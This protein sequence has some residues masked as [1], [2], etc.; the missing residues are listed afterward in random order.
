MQDFQDSGYRIRE[1]WNFTDQ[2]SNFAIFLLLIKSCRKFGVSSPWKFRVSL[3]VRMVREFPSE[4]CLKSNRINRN[5]GIGN[6]RS[7]GRTLR[8][9]Q[10]RIL[11][12]CLAGYF[13]ERV[14]FTYYT[15]YLII[16]NEQFGKLALLSCCQDTCSNSSTTWNYQILN[17]A[18]SFWI[19]S[20][21]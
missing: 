18:I 9:D 12:L 1:S 8:I 15:K 10:R 7:W 6:W 2:Q 4:T 16:A 20:L 13:L 21:C 5:P 19:E 14:T 11:F 17:E 3:R